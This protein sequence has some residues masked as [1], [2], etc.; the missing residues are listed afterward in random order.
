MK[1][2]RTGKWRLMVGV[3]IV[4]TTSCAAQ[5]WAITPGHPQVSVLVS[6]GCPTALGGTQ[7]VVSSYAGNE[8]VP[9][10][11]VG[12]L[13]CRYLARLAQTGASGSPGS[14]YSSVELAT[15][16]AVHLA[17]VIDAIS[18]AAPQ[19]TTS[20]PSD[21]ESAS[22]ITFSYAGRADVD[23]WFSD[24]GCQTLDNGRIGSFEEGN[25]SFYNDFL[26]LMSQL[27]PQQ[28]P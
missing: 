27:V 8:M 18:T 26:T 6:S 25:P 17:T 7:D 9:P 10:N 14:L 16:V 11:P 13:I 21:D 15:S 3:L 2:S 22:I 12:G 5:P 1:R 24:S 23:L 20:C 4:A 28:N 19:G